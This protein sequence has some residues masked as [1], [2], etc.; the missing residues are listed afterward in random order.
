MS[1][2]NGKNIVLG[3]TGSIAAYKVP[4]I[5]RLL[6][7]KGAF[8]FPVMTKNATFFIHPL[9]LQTIAGRKV[10]VDLFEEKE[11]PLKHI[12]LSLI[13]DAVLIA[14]ATANIIGKIANGIADDLLTTTLLATCSPVFIAPAMNHRMFKS[15]QVQENIAKL[16]S[17]GYL[18]IGPEEGELACGEKGKGR[19]SEPAKIVDFL[20]KFFA[21]KKDLE[22]KCILV[23][24]GPTREPLDRVRF[25]SNFSSGKMGF[26]IAQAAKNRGAKVI[27]IKGPTPISPPEGVEVHEVESASEMF[28][29][30][31]AF[32]P[33]TD[34][35]IMSAAVSDFRPLE[36]KEG[37]IKKEKCERLTLTLV[38]NPDI[39]EEMGKN[40][41]EKILVGFCAETENL[42]EEAK[43]KLERKNLDLIVA[44][45]LNYP[46]A[47]F[48][49][50]TNKVFIIN[51]SGRIK[52]HP[53][54]SK[55][56]VAEEILEEVKRLFQER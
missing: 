24:A 44:N 28:E 8:V 20:E 33:Q 35:L 49:T 42:L 46:G 13:A 21:Q 12:N 4:E 6:R 18:F 38:K 39:L 53:L 41:G 50:D 11:D 15:P 40:K 36:A 43:K 17:W 7:E 48:A 47:G 37:K 10:D 5:I 55:R 29:K 52:E 14:P 16:A 51:R 45:N 3:V 27:L 2:L 9:T 56:E 1:S 54:M 19:M 31:K 25:I 26:A 23:T 32:F 34:A 22:G 30:V